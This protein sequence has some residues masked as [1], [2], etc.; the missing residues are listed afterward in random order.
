MFVHRDKTP[1]DELLIHQEHLRQSRD[2]KIHWT[3]DSTSE[4]RSGTA[5]GP[6]L[7]HL[8]VLDSHLD[9]AQIHGLK[10]NR[11]R[12]GEKSTKSV[13]FDESSFQTNMVR[14]CY[15]TVNFDP[16]L[17]GHESL[18]STFVLRHWIVQDRHQS[19][20][21]SQIRVSF[22]EFISFI[23]CGE[24][25]FDDFENF[26]FHANTGRWKTSKASS[27]RISKKISLPMSPIINVGD[28]LVLRLVLNHVAFDHVAERHRV[29]I[30][31]KT[32]Q[33]TMIMMGQVVLA[34][35]KKNWNYVK[36]R[37]KKLRQRTATPMIPTGMV[38]IILLY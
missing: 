25:E 33:A 19:K 27:S 36:L 9:N 34:V 23:L 24:I 1:R 22:K 6:S 15:N 3:C 17:M 35:M 21:K 16:W 4:F 10:S 5:S 12:K 28:I 38:K 7:L 13:K 14:I 32:F 30:L 29:T 18:P 26:E 20:S 11:L 8:E 37:W 2:S 31:S